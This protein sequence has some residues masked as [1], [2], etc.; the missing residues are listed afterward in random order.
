[1]SEKKE[2]KVPRMMWLMHAASITAPTATSQG[3][4][5]MLDPNRDSTWSVFLATLHNHNQCFLSDPN[6]D[7]SQC[8]LPDLCP[9]GLQVPSHAAN[10]SRLSEKTQRLH[11]QISR[12][13][14][15]RETC[16]ATWCTASWLHEGSRQDATKGRRKRENKHDGVDC[17]E[18]SWWELF[19][20]E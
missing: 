10:V 20:V 6:R 1:M 13:L 3:Q 2:P 11:C 5:S 17:V 18:I 16:F 7:V 8:S 9:D 12:L 4:W 19:E 14:S 15:Q